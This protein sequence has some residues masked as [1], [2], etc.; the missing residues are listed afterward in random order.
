MPLRPDSPRL[1]LFEGFGIELEY[2][3]VDAATL[4]VAPVADTLLEAA[5]GARTGECLR[6][7]FAWN[8]ELAR[9]VIE[10]KTNGP[11]ARLGPLAEG[12]AV[13]IRHANA[14][15]RKR[16]CR[17]L[18]TGMHPWMDPARET[19]LWQDD[20]RE[21]YAAFD[22]I[23]SCQGHGWSNLQSMHLNLPFANDAEFGRLHAAI[24]FL[25]PIL[26]GLCASSP[27]RDARITGTLDNRLA[28]YRGNCA[29]VPSVT[30]AVIPEPVYSIGA[31]H[32]QILE[33][34]YRDMAPLDPDLVL[35]HEWIN[36]RGA[37]ARFDRM[38]LEIRVLDTQECP[39]ADLGFAQLIVA[40]LQ[41]LCDEAWV[42]LTALSNWSTESL[43]R[44]FEA[45]TRD[46]E[47]TA[48]HDRRYLEALGLKRSE[49]SVAS[50]WAA[51][52]D[53]AAESGRLDATA[54]RAIEHYLRHGSLATR[55]VSA[56]S[57]EPSREELAAVYRRLADCL[58]GNEL[59]S[60]R[61]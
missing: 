32:E 18:P 27:V 52:A 59:F 14:L 46:G 17:L 38:A 43:A 47:R 23:F 29:R 53:T 26:P 16:H 57:P 22:R 58:A 34:I 8:N 28:A 56:L 24:R 54:E 45:V 15:L 5:S 61:D 50:A 19:V 13:E 36:A 7:D 41:I 55:I 44:A 11:R 60:G 12:F 51:L 39:A 31:Y 1:G 25:M 3:L 10:F 4:D 37:I 9:H 33:R 2:M 6:G 30:G 40:A 21:I 49:A 20:D 35:R 42:D 48:I